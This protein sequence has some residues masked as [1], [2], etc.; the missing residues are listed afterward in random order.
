MIFE[1]D[2]AGQDQPCYSALWM[3]AWDLIL[4]GESLQVPLSLVHHFV[5]FGVLEDAMGVGYFSVS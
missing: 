3:R 4:W 2:H 1:S 5:R